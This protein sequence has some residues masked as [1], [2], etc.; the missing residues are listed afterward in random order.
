VNPV[1]DFP[2]VDLLNCAIW[3][4]H[5]QNELRGFARNYRLKG[6]E[7]LKVVMN[8]TAGIGFPQLWNVKIVWKMF[9]LKHS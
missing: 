4:L 2:E 9:Q 3:I 6:D 8:G 7:A 1:S 5:K